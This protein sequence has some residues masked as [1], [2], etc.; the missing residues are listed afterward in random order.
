MPLWLNV[1]VG[2]TFQ[3]LKDFKRKTNFYSF[4]YI[5]SGPNT[6]TFKFDFSFGKNMKKKCV[7]CRFIQQ[8]TDNTA[9]V[10]MAA[11]YTCECRGPIYVKG[12]GTL[13]T[14]FVRTPFDDKL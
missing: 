2:L 6:G 7:S 5:Y 1:Y 13:I 8:A 10:L 3:Y 11:G 4:R 14:Y 12:K 9:N